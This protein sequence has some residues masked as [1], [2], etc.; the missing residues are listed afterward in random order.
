MTNV[1]LFVLT[2]GA[3]EAMNPRH[4]NSPPDP[5]RP[6]TSTSRLQHA[7]GALLGY[8]WL[9][10]QAPSSP[11]KLRARALGT[12]C[13]RREIGGQQAVHARHEN[14]PPDPTRPTTST[15]RVQL[16]QGTLMGCLAAAA[17]T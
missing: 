8:V 12:G 17:S 15:A 16:A 14:S 6:T 1:Q 4:K 7:Q 5:T 3:T 11:C 13:K 10:L 2:G 9:Q